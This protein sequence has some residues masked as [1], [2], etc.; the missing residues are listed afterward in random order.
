MVAIGLSLLT[1]S[2]PLCA[3]RLECLPC[4]RRLRQPRA[5][6]RGRHQGSQHKHIM[7][8]PRCTGSG[9]VPAMGPSMPS[10]STLRQPSPQL[11]ARRPSRDHGHQCPALAQCSLPPLQPMPPIPCPLTWPC[12]AIRH[13]PLCCRA[14]QLPWR[15]EQACQDPLLWITQ[16]AGSR[17]PNN[18][19]ATACKRPMPLV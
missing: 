14:Q 12:Q 6:R 2:C 9:C 8:R 4:K 1:W 16:N 11:T 19:S 3:A 18:T 7:H 15:V 5:N 10:P 17:Q 13:V